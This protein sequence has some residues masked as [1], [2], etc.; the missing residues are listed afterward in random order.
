MS[1]CVDQEKG[2]FGFNALACTQHAYKL[3]LLFYLVTG[4]LDFGIE[5]A[6]V[7]E[8]VMSQELCFLVTVP[9]SQSCV[10]KLKF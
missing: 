2:T 1:S 5:M 7:Q 4:S 6:S 3:S 8:D 9:V 10:S